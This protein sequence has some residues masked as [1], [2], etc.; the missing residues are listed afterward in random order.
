MARLARDAAEA[1]LAGRASYANG[2]S[3]CGPSPSAQALLASTPVSNRSQ[4]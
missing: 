1:P 3:A 4:G 2:G